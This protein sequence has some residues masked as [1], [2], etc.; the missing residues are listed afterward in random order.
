MHET[1]DN[2]PAAANRDAERA[3]C[4][5]ERELGVLRSIYQKK[6]APVN[7]N[8][9]GPSNVVTRVTTVWFLYLF[10]SFFLINIFSSYVVTSFA[11]HAALLQ[12]SIEYN[13]C[14]IGVYFVEYI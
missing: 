6:K 9:A 10:L 3:I 11:V 7:S 8:A 5:I 2:P 4:N 13:H 1:G 14:I 12:I